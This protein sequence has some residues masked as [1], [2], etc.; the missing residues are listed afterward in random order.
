MDEEELV[1]RSKQ[2]DEEAFASLV[3]AYKKRVFHLT[4]SLTRDQEVADDLAQEVFLKVFLALP[5]FRERSRFGTWLY[6]I[7]VNHTKD[8]LRKKGRLK[9]VRL[10]EAMEGR[11]RLEDETMKRE[12][13]TDLEKKSRII[14]EVIRT[15]PEKYQLILS[16][17]DIQALPYDEISR[18]LR[19]SPGTVDSRIHRARKMLRERVK[20]LLEKKEGGYE[21]P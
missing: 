13:E 20:A 17:R 14:Y 10:D 12:R 2:G 3:N 9:Q 15:L 19:I 21:V 16:L 7:A 11:E 18:A 4:Y 6:Q 8:F 5:K 1:R